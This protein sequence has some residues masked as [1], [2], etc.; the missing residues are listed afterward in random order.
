MTE[1]LNFNI[2]QS[3]DFAYGVE[4]IGMKR[5][6][7]GVV[8]ALVAVLVATIAR[9]GQAEITAEQVQQ[10]ISRGVN[11]LKQQQRN[12]GSWP[13]WLG[14][15]G[16]VTALCTLALINAGESPESSTV[17][18]ALSWLRKLPPEKTYVVALQTMVLCRAE[19]K[20]DLLLISRNVKWLEKHQVSDGPRKGA[21]SYPGQAAG[22]NSNSQFALLALY[23]AERVGVDV[24]DKT[25]RLARAYWEEAQAPNGGWGYYPGLPPT[26]SMTCAGIASMVIT[27][28][29]VFSA[30]AEAEGERIRCCV[31][32]TADDSRIQ[33]GLQWLGRNF[34]VSG[35][36]GARG[37]T[38]MLYYLY[39]VE[40]VGRLTAQRFIGDHDWY[41]EGADLLVRNQD[42]L[43]GYW[44]GVGHAEDNPQIA[45]SLV[46]LFLSKGRRPVLLSKL[47]FGADEHWNRHRSDV[48]NLTRYV[49]S[50]WDREMTWQI[51]D[52]GAADVDDLLQSP[53]LYMV[54]SRSPLPRSEEDQVV[55]AQK[56]RDYLDRGGF[57]LAEG[58]CG[59]SDFD[60]GFRRLLELVFPEPEYRLR[61]LPPSH[62]IWR[63]EE[64][65]PPEQLRPLWG[66]EFGCRTSLVYAPPD[67]PERPRP[68]LSC[69][70]E[71]MR[72]G[73]DDTLAKSVEAQVDAGRA[74]GI[75]ILAYATNRQLKYKDEIPSVVT[76]A[77]P[78]DAFQ[79]GRLYIASLR[80]PGGCDAAPRAL[81]NLLEAAGS[82]L[83][84]RT[85]PVR[86]QVALTDKSLFLY[87]LVFM[88]GRTSFR[89][90]EPERKQ[91]AEFIDRGGMLFADSI[92][93]SQAF[94]ES[95]RREMAAIFPQRKLEM[96]Q[97]E[98]PILS[99]QYGGFDLSTVT[100]RDPQQRGDRGPLKASL[101]EVPPLLEGIKIDDRWAVV[102]SPFDISCALEKHDSLECQGY[103]REDAARIGL[104]VILYSLQQ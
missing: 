23:E 14:Y 48:A 41:R 81:T 88:H 33:R 29:K 59:G 1:A 75:N 84:I 57:L 63:A 76:S 22:D 38:W 94:T 79:R 98:D 15:S 46:L 90:T 87:H 34:S 27:S 45:T 70:W 73:R 39:G 104:N 35:N 85:T 80:H 65:V 55:L 86:R 44:K 6:L 58:Y 21:W 52:V 26:G 51:V 25:W 40:R 37:Q 50:R 83:K 82:E 102:F 18:K 91:L 28:D 30:G 95:F 99:E 13:E 74:I 62:P 19:P 2:L 5:P 61:P 16:G 56:L 32:G 60:R 42:Q 49:E 89:L 71:L 8:L 64:P 12:D 20:K 101:R 67:P 69:L 7:A 66:M 92:C 31:E 72:T 36:P 4:N 53:V 43:S 3:N 96:I 54:G 77:P 11:Y 47:D 24:S 93:A 78:A 97:R 9:T 68:S 17:Q 10:S 103:T 100:R